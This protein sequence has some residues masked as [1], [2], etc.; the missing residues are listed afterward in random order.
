MIIKKHGFQIYFAYNVQLIAHADF[1]NVLEFKL[2]I[3]KYF[4]KTLY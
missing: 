4:R 1:I 3:W 2:S